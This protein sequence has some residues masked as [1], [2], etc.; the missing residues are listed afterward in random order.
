[1]FS[2]KTTLG[3]ADEDQNNLLFE[4]TEFNK[5]TKPKN[6]GKNSKKYTPFKA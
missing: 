5:N 6:A 4:I 1:M 3:N 2:G